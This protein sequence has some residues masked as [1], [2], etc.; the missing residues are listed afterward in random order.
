MCCGA[1]CDTLQLPQEGF[2]FSI[3]EEV[4]WVEGGHEGREGNEIGVHDVKFTKKQ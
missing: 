1:H 3:V 4:A 2:F